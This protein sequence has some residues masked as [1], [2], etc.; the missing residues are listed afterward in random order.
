MGTMTHI[1][2]RAA[3]SKAVD[4]V[5]KNADKDREKEI[6]KLVDLM[7]KYMGSEKIDVDYNKVKCVS[8]NSTFIHN[9]FYSYLVK[10]FACKH[11]QKSINNS[12]L[13]KFRHVVLPLFHL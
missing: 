5:L 9:F 11:F 13:C 4:I 10:R 1:A 2:G 7:E 6:T 12:L 3:F 8:I